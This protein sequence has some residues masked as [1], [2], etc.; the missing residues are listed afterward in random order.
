MKTKLHLITAL[1]FSL[2]F[3]CTYAQPDFFWAKQFGGSTSNTHGV[4]VAVDAAGNVY[5]VG[6]FSDTV[7]FDPGP[8]VFNLISIKNTDG[9]FSQDIYIS[10]LD[11][12]GNF[13]WAK[14]IGGANYENPAGMAIDGLGNIYTTGTFSDTLDFDPGAGVFNLICMQSIPGEPYAD[15]FISKLDSAGN[16]VWAKSFGGP[17]W[18]QTNSMTAD[19][20]GNVYIAGLFNDTIDFDPGAGVSDLIP[21]L[22]GGGN[23]TYDFYINKLDV[24]GNFVW[25]KSFGGPYNEQV[26]VGAVAVD[27]SGNVLLTGGYAGLVNFGVDAGVDSLNSVLHD[28]FPTED[29]FIVKLNA[30][31]NYVWA[32]SMSGPGNEFGAVI[33]VD[34]NGDVYSAGSFNDTIDF[35]PGAGSYNLTSEGPY[36][37]VYVSKLHSNGTF[38]WV[39]KLGGLSDEYPTCITVDNSRNVYTSGIFAETADF[40]PGSSTY[41]LTSSGGFDVFTSKLSSDGTF[42]WANRFGGGYDDLSLGITVNTTDDVFT[43]GL[44]ID[45]VDFDSGA[46]VFNMVSTPNISEGYNSDAFVLKLRT[47]HVGILGQISIADTPGFGI[48]PNPNNGE[49]NLTMDLKGEEKLTI[50][51]VDVMGKAVKSIDQPKLNPGINSVAIDASGLS[52]GIYFMKVYNETI[53]ATMK[54]LIS[55]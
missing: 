47:S 42:L 22:N 29:I 19:P 14:R 33:T 49:F 20:A 52:N 21:K 55:N 11:A 7:D 2:S 1:F 4:S 43:T 5:T 51:I 23:F 27:E 48:Y 12:S 35:D 41:N 32:K 24:S 38:E 25:A 44:F 39:M 31:G 53:N 6:S 26:G 15:I 40:D 46:G 17:A 9:E 34:S 36:K 16:F 10:K 45:T 50:D 37:D 3:R 30:S 54:I 18:D 28:D 8:G 13:I